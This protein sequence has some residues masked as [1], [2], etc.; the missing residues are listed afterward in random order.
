MGAGKFN[1]GGKPW[2][3]QLPILG[4]VEIVLIS[5]ARET[6]GKCQTDGPLGL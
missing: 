3:D 4:R 6:E 2:M 1:G 5:Y